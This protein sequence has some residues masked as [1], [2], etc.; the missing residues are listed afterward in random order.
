MQTM[1]VPVI[2]NITLNISQR[3]IDSSEPRTTGRCMIAQALRF[4]GYDSVDVN[5]ERVS[6]RHNGFRFHYDIP[7]RA[8]KAVQD[9]DDYKVVKP[10]KVVLHTHQGSVRPVVLKGPSKAK[11]RKPYTRSPGPRNCKR[12]FHGLRVVAGA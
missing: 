5:A 10:F 8:K 11:K 1:T 6:F 3:V 2:P 12:R 4:R 9:F 7:A